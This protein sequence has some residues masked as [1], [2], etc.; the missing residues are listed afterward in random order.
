MSAN[1]VRR[2]GSLMFELNAAKFL[3]TLQEVQRIK[4]VIEAAFDD[5][6]R[7]ADVTGARQGLF[8]SLDE[9]GGVLR[10]R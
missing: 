5:A 3:D 6:G 8:Q 2:R 10:T 7:A 4:T 9:L 1:R